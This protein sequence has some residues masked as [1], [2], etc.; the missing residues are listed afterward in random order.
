MYFKQTLTV[1][2]QCKVEGNKSLD[3]ISIKKLPYKYSYDYNND[4]YL[5]L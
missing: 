1:L 3:A 5:L 2:I 4:F